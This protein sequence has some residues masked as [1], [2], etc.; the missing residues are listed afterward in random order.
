MELTD[1]LPLEKWEALE[2]EIHE[3]SGLE[4]SVFNIKGIRITDNKGWVNRLCPAIKGT[5]KGQSFICAVAHMNIAEQARQTRKAA[6][7]EC[8]AGLMKLVVPIFKGDDFLGAVGACGLLL[9]DGEVDP[10]L[11]NK[12]TGIPEK[13]IET[14]S[15]GIG[16]IPEKD[17][18]SLALFITNRI[19]DLI[20]S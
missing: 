17:A 12:T 2:K 6:I 20:S 7:E 1:V 18:Q 4:A 5:D 16:A 9:G 19:E 13:R 15:E 3:R 10:F 14:L 11:I 8:D